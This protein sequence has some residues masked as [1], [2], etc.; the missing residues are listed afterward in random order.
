MFAE[1]NTRIAAIVLALALLTLAGVATAQAPGRAAGPPIVNIK[2]LKDNIYIASG[3]T[4]SNNGIVI[5][6]SGVIVIDTA[7][8]PDAEKLEV[9]EIAKITPKPVTAAIITHSDGDHVNGLGELPAGITIVSQ[10]NCKKEMEAAEN[11]PARGG[12]PAPHLPLPTKTIDT[13]G[14][15]TIDGVR[16]EFLH[17]APAHTSGDLMIYLPDEKVVFTGDIIAGDGF[18]LIHL[19]KH[20]SSAGW[21]QTVTELLKWDAD[22]FVPGHGMPHTK[23]EIEQRLASVKE[24][25]AQI[26]SLVKQGKSL[27]EIKQALGESAPAAGGRGPRFPSFIEVVY[28]ELTKKS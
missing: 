23:A 13:K 18:P 24:R 2:Q 26:E 12:M 11:A 15:V 5:G 28:E 3:S 19:E 22:T 4:A 14:A 6:K 9:E 17:V 1:K 10:E 21:I 8:T 25:R 27:G 20:G 16:F 7:I